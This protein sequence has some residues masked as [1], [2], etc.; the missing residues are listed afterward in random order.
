M[1]HKCTRCEQIFDDGAAAILN[2]CPNCGWNKFLYVQ[3]ETQKESS[4]N[5]PEKIDTEG[6]Q[7]TT[8]AERFINEVDQILGV[9]VT[10]RNIS[11]EMEGEKVESVKILGPGSYELNLDSLL[12]RKEIIMAIKEDGSYALH[13]PSVF[14]EKKKK[15]K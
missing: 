1:P 15:Q 7:E 12:N 2:G 4:E 14:D 13:L 10:K 6:N 3:K 8:P 9:D 5:L 11:S